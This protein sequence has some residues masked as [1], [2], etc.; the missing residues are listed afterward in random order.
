GLY[1]LLTAAGMWAT[2]RLRGERPPAKV[3]WGKLALAVSA[4]AAYAVLAIGL[5]LDRFVT[6]FLPTPGRLPLVLA[7]LVGTALYFAADEWLTRGATA[8]RGGYAVTKL[9]FLVSLALAIALDPPRLFFLIIIVPAILIFFVVY[10]LLSGWAYRRTLH[11]FVGALANA[12]AFAWAT[13]VTF[14][15]VGQ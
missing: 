6:S 15:V 7:V 5:P 3:A 4:V 2:G 11:P 13:A 1:G 14:P 12:I 9:C 10:G 8:P